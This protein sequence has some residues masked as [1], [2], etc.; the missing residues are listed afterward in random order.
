M[1]DREFN[2]MF[3][4]KINSDFKIFTGQI[5]HLSQNNIEPYLTVDSYTTQ[6][7]YV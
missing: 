2:S 3:Q 5:F 4:N 7:W 6:L 1:Y